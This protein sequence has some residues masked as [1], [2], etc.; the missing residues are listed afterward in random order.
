MLRTVDDGSNCLTSCFLIH[1]IGD[2]MNLLSHEVGYLNLMNLSLV[3]ILECLCL[4][5]NC[6]WWCGLC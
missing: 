6:E 2:S 1:E 4:M 5:I 3:V